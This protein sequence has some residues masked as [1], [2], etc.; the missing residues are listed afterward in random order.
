MYYKQKKNASNTSNH[1][2]SIHFYM[3][4][5]NGIQSHHSIQSYPG[6][7]CFKELPNRFASTTASSTGKSGYCR[8]WLSSV[9]LRE[10]YHQFA[11]RAFQALCA[12]SWQSRGGMA[13]KE[14][15]AWWRRRT[16]LISGCCSHSSSFTI[17]MYL[18]HHQTELQDWDSAQITHQQNNMDR[19]WDIISIILTF[20]EAYFR[21]MSF[22]VTR[23]RKG[24]TENFIPG[25]HD[26][27]FYVSFLS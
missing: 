5:L 19:V 12:S 14:H 22:N 26:T 17:T 18:P 20:R 3:N 11:E 27:C 8:G 10:A 1:F 16:T 9:S 23:L 24:Q 13:H 6:L 25:W 7:W 15:L 21:W 2:G 4:R